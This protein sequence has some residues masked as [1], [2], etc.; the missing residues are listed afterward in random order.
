MALNPYRDYPKEINLIMFY[1]S[2]FGPR[3]CPWNLRTTIFLK[4]S[5]LSTRAT[6]SIR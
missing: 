6:F 3:V 2:I 4:I 1:P 5:Y